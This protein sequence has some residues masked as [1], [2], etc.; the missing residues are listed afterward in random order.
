MNISL[1]F[2]PRRKSFGLSSRDEH[3]TYVKRGITTAVRTRTNVARM[4]ATK[5]FSCFT[6]D[7]NCMKCTKDDAR[8]A[9]SASLPEKIGK[10]KS[11]SQQIFIGLFIHVFFVILFGI[12]W[13]QTFQSKTTTK[14]LSLSPTA[15]KVSLS[16]PGIICGFTTRSITQITQSSTDSSL[17]SPPTSARSCR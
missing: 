1:K 17:L 11:F 8:T 13:F 2:E 4:K 10:L 3:E 12:L 7:G 14:F 5:C 16:L 6:K 15:G 9:W